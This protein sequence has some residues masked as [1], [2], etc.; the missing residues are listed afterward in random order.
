MNQVIIENKYFEAL[1]AR[2]EVEVVCLHNSE[3]P[4]KIG[5]LIDYVC[6]SSSGKCK[7]TGKV[8]DVLISSHKFTTYKVQLV[9]DSG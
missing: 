5:E 1:N 7:V 6:G 8:G 9:M 3:L 2:Q 4:L